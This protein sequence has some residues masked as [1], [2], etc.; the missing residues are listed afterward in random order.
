MKMKN[1]KRS[2]GLMEHQQA[3]KCIHYWYLTRRREKKNKEES[4]FGKI[5]NS[6]V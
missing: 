1:I 6:D 4:L 2:K 5:I 3:D